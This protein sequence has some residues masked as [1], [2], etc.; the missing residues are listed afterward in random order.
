M[1]TSAAKKA[2]KT[3]LL[4]IYSI[5]SESYR[6]VYAVFHSSLEAIGYPA[7]LVI[8]K[9]YDDSGFEARGFQTPSW[10]FAI[11]QKLG[12]IIEQVKANPGKL[13]ISSDVDIQFFPPFMEADIGRRMEEKRLDMLFMREM[14]REE[15]PI[16][17]GFIAIRCT[18]AVGQLLESV[19]ERIRKEQLPFADQTAFTEALRSREHGVQFETIPMDLVIWGTVIPPAILKAWFHHAVCCSTNAEK[20]AQ[21]KAIQ[22]A[23]VAGSTWPRRAA[24]P[25]RVLFRL[26]KAFLK[27]FF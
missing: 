9:F 4:P 24:H 19:L 14:S 8:T 10:Y 20:L 21:F 25:A 15:P 7:E 12:F 17:G 2:P 23:R 26:L 22:A 13:I 1:V 6:E 5:C 3:P 11:Q 18:E 27:R 16:N